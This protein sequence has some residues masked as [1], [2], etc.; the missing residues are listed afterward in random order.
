MGRRGCRQSSQGARL[1]RRRRRRCP[2]PRRRPDVLLRC[3]P[4]CHYTL[5]LTSFSN[6]HTNQGLE[7]YRGPAGLGVKVGEGQ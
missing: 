4:S 1:H 2:D 7:Y 5:F 6:C 3:L